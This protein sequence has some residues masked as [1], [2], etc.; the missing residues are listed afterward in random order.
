[1]GRSSATN[2]PIAAGKFRKERAAK[3]L[4]EALEAFVESLVAQRT[5][6][7]WVDQDTSPLGRRHHLRAY[8]AGRLRGFKVG[9]KVLVEEADLAAYIKNY[10][11]KPAVRSIR[12]DADADLIADALDALGVEPSP[13]SGRGRR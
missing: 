10:G 6:A 9:K 8:R 12:S 4:L 3:V 1:M 7:H 11:E 2:E 5:S 13:S